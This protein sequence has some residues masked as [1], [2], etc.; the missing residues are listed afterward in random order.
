MA[1]KSKKTVSMFFSIALIGACVLG[2]SAAS[3]KEN[4]LMFHGQLVN[5]GCDAKVIGAGIQQ[6]DLKALK[7]NP[8]L[9]I[10]L[11]NHDD[12]CDGA[13]VPVSTAYAEHISIS[14]DLRGGVVTLTYQ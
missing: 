4:V 8:V 1:M 9:S 12:A 6:H 11:V 13:A 5:A 10:G 14:A 3:A 2:G 7:I